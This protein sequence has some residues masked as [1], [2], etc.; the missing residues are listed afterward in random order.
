MAENAEYFRV[1]PNDICTY[2]FD[3]LAAD[4]INK[5]HGGEVYNNVGDW[6]LKLEWIN[7]VD[8]G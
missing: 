5:R 2:S 7:V 8:L 4:T 6:D 1:L 3:H